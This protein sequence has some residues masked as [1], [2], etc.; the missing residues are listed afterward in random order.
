MFC[1]DPKTCKVLYLMSKTTQE[2][3]FY[4]FFSVILLA[5]FTRVVLTNQV[6]CET[7]I[8]S[9]GPGWPGPCDVKN[10]TYCVENDEVYRRDTMI[11]FMRTWYK[12]IDCFFI[13]IYLPCRTL[14]FSISPGC[15]FSICLVRYAIFRSKYFPAPSKDCQRR[16]QKTLQISKT[17]RHGHGASTKEGQR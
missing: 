14:C 5:W 8:M 4:S 2:K 3:Y 17:H 6:N 10:V 7:F 11:T 1:F 16:K 9:H 15:T 12:Y 13:G